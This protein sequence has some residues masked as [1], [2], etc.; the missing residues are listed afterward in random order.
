LLAATATLTAAAIVPGATAADRRGPAA[1]AAREVFVQETGHLHSV[2][3]T[4]TTIDEQGRATGTYNCAI[5]V[6]LTIVSA[7]RVT[8][9][10]TVRPRGG[11]ISGRGS[12]RFKTQGANGYFGG[13]IS[14]TRGTG[15]FR[16]A[17]GA[18]IG[19][20]GVINRETFN[21]TVHVHGTIH[22]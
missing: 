2:N 5:T 21:L 15:G 8:A 20:S 3:D 6:H 12:A 4:G 10:F 9:A 11:A 16:H 19:I 22:V 18:N 17:A 14:I 1:R 13:T 7:N